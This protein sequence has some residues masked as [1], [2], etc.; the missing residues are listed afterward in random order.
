[1]GNVSERQ[2]RK[3]PTCDCGVALRLGSVDPLEEYWWCE[4]CG[5]GPLSE[6]GEMRSTIIDDDGNI[7]SYSRYHKATST[8]QD[9]RESNERRIS[10]KNLSLQFERMM[11]Q[12]LENMRRIEEREKL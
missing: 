5:K 1:M 2:S 9:W 6:G 10:F 3:P 7:G 12:E 4:E 8:C 11:N